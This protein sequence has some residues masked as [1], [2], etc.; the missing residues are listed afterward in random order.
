MDQKSF[1]IN[2]P[3]G[4]KKNATRRLTD[5]PSIMAKEESLSS[6][7]DVD[8]SKTTAPTPTSSMLGTPP[9][10]QKPTKVRINGVEHTYLDNPRIKQLHEEARKLEAQLQRIEPTGAVGTKSLR[11]DGANIYLELQRLQGLKQQIDGQPPVPQSKGPDVNGLWHVGY[12]Y[13]PDTPNPP[14][15]LEKSKRDPFEKLPFDYKSFQ[16]MLD[17]GDN[18]VRTREGYALPRSHAEKLVGK[19]TGQPGPFHGAP[20]QNQRE[21]QIIERGMSPN[22]GGKLFTNPNRERFSTANKYLAELGGTLG[23]VYQ[24]Q[25]GL[26]PEDAPYAHAAL[27]FLGGLITSPLQMAKGAAYGVQHPV[28]AA[29]N[30]P[31]LLGDAL[32]SVNAFDPN[33]SGPD[34]FGRLLNAV[35]MVA[36]GVHFGK[37]LKGAIA[38]GSLY[39]L[40]AKLGLPEAETTKLA[41]DYAK[42][43]SEIYNSNV[44]NAQTLQR[45]D[46][47]QASHNTPKSFSA[48]DPLGLQTH[49]QAPSAP[50][51][52]A[53]QYEPATDPLGLGIPVDYSTDGWEAP[54]PHANTGKPKIVHPDDPEVVQAENEKI[55]KAARKQGLHRLAADE[56]DTWASEHD[57]HIH[58]LVTPDQL[59]A[60]AKS[61]MSGRKQVDALNYL[62][63]NRVSDPY[64]LHRAIDIFKNNEVEFL[65]DNGDS[66]TDKAQRNPEMA[67]V[68][69]EGHPGVLQS[70]VH[71][72]QDVDAGRINR[73]DEARRSWLDAREASKKS[74]PKS[75]APVDPTLKDPIATMHDGSETTPQGTT[76]PKVIEPTKAEGEKVE[77]ASKKEKKGKGGLTAS[78][79]GYLTEHLKDAASNLPEKIDIRTNAHGGFIG[80]KTPEGPSEGVSIKVPGDGEFTVH[81]Q[82]QAKALND[83]FGGEPF[84][85]KSPPHPKDFYGPSNSYIHGEHDGDVVSGTPEI[86]FKGEH[87]AHGVI[88]DHA[89]GKTSQHIDAIFDGAKGNLDNIAKPAFTDQNKKTVW[90]K[91]NDGS[92]TP[93]KKQLADMAYKRGYEI[94]SPEDAK[95]PLRIVDPTTGETKGVMVQSAPTPPPDQTAPYKAPKPPKEKPNYSAVMEEAPRERTLFED[96]NE[97]KSPAPKATPAPAT[98]PIPVSPTITVS[99]VQASELAKA[100]ESL[101]RTFAPMTLGQEAKSVGLRMRE[102]FGI[103]AATQARDVYALRKA[104]DFFSKQTPD[105]NYEFINRMERGDPQGSPELDAFAQ[106]IRKILDTKRDAVRALGKGQLAN[107]YTNYFPHMFEKPSAVAKWIDNL[108]KQ[109]RPLEGGKGALKRRT[110][111]LLEHAMSKGY[112]LISDNP[113][114]VVIAHSHQMDMYVEAHHL[115]EHLK[116]NGHVKYKKIG[117]PM[118]EGWSK[119]ND[120]LFQVNHSGEMMIHEAFD[121]KLMGQLT[122]LARTLKVSHER[123]VGI[124]G[125]PNAWGIESKAG[126][127]TKFGGPETVLT[128]EIGH[129]IDRKYGLRRALFQGPERDVTLAEMKKLAAMR[130]DGHQVSKSYE[131]YTQ[132]Q[133]ELVANL[134]HAYVHAPHLLEKLAPETTKLFDKFIDT[135]PDLH[136]LRDIKPSLVLAGNDATI[137]APGVHILGDYIAPSDVAAVMNNAL[138]KGI[139]NAQG[140]K[141]YLAINNSQNQLNL[142]LSAFHYS[143]TGFNSMISSMALGIEHLYRNDLKGAIKHG[144]MGLNPGAIVRD[145]K[146]GKSVEQAYLEGI[147]DPRMRKIVEGVIK[148]GGRIKQDELYT[149]QAVKAFTKAWGRKEA[150]GV[151]KSAPF[152]ATEKFASHLMETVIPRVKIGAFSQMLQSD[153][154]AFKGPMTDD[155][156]RAMAAK[157]WDSIDNRMGAVV[158]SNMFWHPVLKDITMATVRSAGWT[159]GT[160]RELGGGITD[161]AGKP[162]AIARYL[163]DKSNMSPVKRASAMTDIGTLG[164]RT[165]YMFAMPIVTGVYGSLLNYLMTGKLPQNSNDVYFP[166]TGR[167]NADGTDERLSL[168]SYMKDVIGYTNDLKGTLKA[169]M[170]PLP[171]DLA[172]IWTGEDYFGNK[173]VSED[174]PLYKKGISALKYFGSSAMPFTAQTIAQQYQDTGKLNYLGMAGFNKAPSSI[175]KSEAQKLAEHYAYEQVPKGGRTSEQAKRQS[176]LSH[177]VGLLRNGDKDGALSRMKDMEVTN[178]EAKYIMSHA[179]GDVLPKLI[180]SLS[181]DQA[182]RVLEAGT[183]AER[184]L[185]A[186]DVQKKF[187][188][189]VHTNKKNYSAE[190]F[191]GFEKRLQAALT[192]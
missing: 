123:V 45:V 56:L 41:I 184:K 2:D 9:Q 115:L 11:Q 120:P 19:A 28:E 192:R 182:I 16:T 40:G 59:D 133:Q 164:H 48:D 99:P 18:I 39:R 58:K 96:T 160:I 183:D 174:D 25:T 98:A 143:T 73:F 43:Q 72:Q 140:M 5:A 101:K 46:L 77:K 157:A 117:A 13:Q 106:S 1:N 104:H 149:N 166:L 178:T 114:D 112:K 35:T 12:N 132:K 151:V 126:I 64:L 53:V 154:D 169:K 70:L 155:Q 145:Y 93:V 76:K 4:L 131:K 83:A 103:L 86:L 3:L 15:S 119:L 137:R 87:N 162:V 14:L 176:D 146:V 20:L 94:L 52:H 54:Q 109:K 33:I 55:L 150:W 32:T 144:A 60:L 190:D 42:K 188:N 128:H 175:T 136:V 148:G 68:K 171:S 158:Y 170:A 141:Q 65:D 24:A 88:R 138:G 79:V 189:A 71:S 118:P 121:E 22:S 26:R 147:G 81:S 29:R 122:D 134:V 113:V 159:V 44:Q 187:F 47:N 165:A 75:P 57:T 17:N 100:V 30:T 168:P 191:K 181:I 8:K 78:Q 36:G 107:Y 6:R 102:H 105:D 92:L 85:G 156:F 163:K 63:A 127:K 84:E 111:G 49:H 167:K 125:K 50:S 69:G 80:F 186:K 135:H 23:K 185:I 31:Q 34:R 61:G 90:L 110:H 51:P 124:K 62:V 82:E 67:V 97:A 129:A 38:D 180:K 37:F 21:N 142:G 91:S 116:A 179:Q 153:L 95:Q 172:S 108:R 10:A 7:L 89:E 177:I 27:D 66:A 130:Y 139:R 173:I 152:A 161:S 74:E